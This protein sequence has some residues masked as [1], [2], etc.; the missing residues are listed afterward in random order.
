MSWRPQGRCNF[1]SVGKHRLDICGDLGALGTEQGAT[2]W[3]AMGTS[4]AECS[5]WVPSLRLPSALAQSQVVP[6]NSPADHHTHHPTPLLCTS[7]HLCMRGIF[8]HLLGDE[9]E[10]PARACLHISH[11]AFGVCL[12]VPP[13]HREDQGAHA[14]RSLSCKWGHF[15]S[16]SPRT[17]WC[18]GSDPSGSLMIQE[19]LKLG[20]SSWSCPLHHQKHKSTQFSTSS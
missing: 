3:R 7:G 16:E 1:Q 11:V 10:P 19:L 20:F 4:S 5:I 17:V 12:P 9:T 14:Q 6:S 13:L 15:S 18:L 8:P 2:P